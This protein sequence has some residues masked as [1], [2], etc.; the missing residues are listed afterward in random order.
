MKAIKTLMIAVCTVAFLTSATLA[1]ERKLTCCEKAIADGKQCKNKCC[2][3][4][5]KNGK[6]CEKCNPNQEDLT[7]MK[8]VEKKDKK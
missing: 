7:A 3:S 6:S 4:A 8:K 5:H 2:L 1:A